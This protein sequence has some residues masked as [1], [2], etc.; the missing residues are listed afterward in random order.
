MTQESS[1]PHPV[2]QSV[3]PLDASHMCLVPADRVRGILAAAVSHAQ[4]LLLQER[5]RSLQLP[6]LATAPAVVL[7]IAC[8]EGMVSALG[9]RVGHI[10]QCHLLGSTACMSQA[11][12]LAGCAS[13]AG[14]SHAPFQWH[15]PPPHL[16]PRRHLLLH[17]RAVA[18]AAGLAGCLHPL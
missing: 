7:T 16:R 11:A 9:P 4:L 10:P 8:P 14:T 12:A 2:E 15:S 5:G 1:S 13:R 17:R 18:S 6:H 3:R